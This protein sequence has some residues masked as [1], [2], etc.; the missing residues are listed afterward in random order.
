MHSDNVCKRKCF[1]MDSSTILRIYEN[2]VDNE[3]H[4]NKKKVWNSKYAHSAL[5]ASETV[6][7][8]LKLGTW[9]KIRFAKTS[10]Y[11]AYGHYKRTS[12]MSIQH[13]MLYMKLQVHLP[14]IGRSTSGLCL[15]CVKIETPKVCTPYLA[16]GR[17]RSQ[18]NA[19]TRSQTS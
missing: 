13:C 7:F 9:N 4:A 18:S 10:V 16:T 6:W 5:V 8:R 3:Y 1:Q 14:S 19:H 12:C 15:V 17:T 11:T 2:R